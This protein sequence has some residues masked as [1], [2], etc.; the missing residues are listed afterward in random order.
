MSPVICPSSQPQSNLNDRSRMRRHISGERSRI[1][2]LQENSPGAGELAHQA[3]SGAHSADQ[4][5][6]SHALE[7]ILAGPGHQVAVID[8]VAFAF[9]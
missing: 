1:P 2:R 9:L 7:N 3:F 5:T 6:R 4:A 8:D